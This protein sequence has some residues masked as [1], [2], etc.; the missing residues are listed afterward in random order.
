MTIIVGALCEDGAVFGADESMTVT[1]PGGGHAIATH[2]TDK[3]RLLCGGRAAFLHTGDVGVGQRTSAVL[4][5]WVAA[6]KNLYQAST[7]TIMRDFKTKLV[8][9]YSDEPLVLLARKHAEKGQIGNP[10]YFTEMSVKHL[11][12]GIL[13][14]QSKGGV[15]VMAYEGL[16]SLTYLEKGRI[17]H[18]VNGSGLGTG[19]P[20]LAFIQRVLWRGTIPSRRD[21]LL[22]VY[23]TIRHAINTG[24]SSG[25]GGNPALGLITVDAGKAVNCTK[26]PDAEVAELEATIEDFESK[27]GELFHAPV[28]KKE[29]V[30]KP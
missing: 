18:F 9:A 19:D 6:S 5:A 15:A 30:P 2:R 27:I 16:K 4:E 3:I 20:F 22:G 23:W 14:T 11:M 12:S 1:I 17:H 8:E 24:S 28:A 7:D 13:V 21:A 29:E 26:L 10:D 25:V